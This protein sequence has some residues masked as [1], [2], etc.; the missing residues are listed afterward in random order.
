VDGG[1]ASRPVGAGPYIKSIE[2]SH[3]GE[4]VTCALGEQIRMEVRAEPGPGDGGDR[5]PG[6]RFDVG[7]VTRI[8]DAGA[9]FFVW[10]EYDDAESEW[11]AVFMVGKQHRPEV[12]R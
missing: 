11:P 6:V 8:E 1:D 7:P 3:G 5:R 2:W 12:R 9:C 4:T 10:H